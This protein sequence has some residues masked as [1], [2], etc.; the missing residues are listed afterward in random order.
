MGRFG[1][2]GRRVLHSLPVALAVLLATFLLLQLVPGDPARAVAGPRATDEAVAAVRDD[3]GLDEPVWVQ[4]GKYLGRVSSGDLGSSAVSHVPVSRIVD[5]NAP[6]TIWLVM[7]GATM[8]VL[9]A[10][11][12]ALLAATSR[13]RFLDR[14][15]RAAT[16]VGLT[17]PPFWIGLL[18]LEFAAVRAGWFPVGGWP[19]GWWGRLHTIALPAITLGLAV[20][21]LLV[22]SLRA[23][24]IQ[25]L[26]SDHVVAARAAGVSGVRLVRLFVLRNSLVPT[27][28]LLATTVG[29][30]LFGAVLVET[31]FGLPGLG[32]TMVQA[33]ISRDFNVVQGLTLVFAL[34]TVAVNLLGDIVLAGL[35]P[36]I[37][38]GR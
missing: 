7:G 12:A 29:Y 34:S 22:R 8:S 31:V 35:D 24:V 9:L 11:P 33:A 30:L 20:A 6:V 25:V 16:M 32:Q 15:I 2:V 36:R 37:R 27:I 26:G 5:Q 18:L 3:L 23:A 1:F 17:V 4:F 13:G 28:A 10:V 14:S 38:V 21:P 19:R